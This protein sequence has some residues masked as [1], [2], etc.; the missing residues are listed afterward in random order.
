MNAVERISAA[1]AQAQN[2]LASALSQLNE[3]RAAY[4]QQAGPQYAKAKAD[5][6]ALDAKIEAAL[7]EQ[8]E[9]AADFQREFAAAGFEKTPAVAA[10]LRRRGEAQAMAESMMA[11]RDKLESNMPEIHIKA[12][13]LARDYVVSYR[14][15]QNVYAQT[16]AYEALLSAGATIGRAM[17]LLSHVPNEPTG[18]EDFLGRPPH[19][20]RAHEELS[21]ARM[22]SI[23]TDLCA[24]AYACPEFN[25]FP[26]FDGLGELDLI[27]L[28]AQDILSPAQ[29]HNLR[30]ASGLPSA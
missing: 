10:A 5:L 7:D 27:A 4:D 15:A 11:G 19:S 17:A 6:A 18:K 24:F 25:E 2:K 13:H 22:G 12:S 3:A 1:A 21:L 14:V 9:A 30:R 8:N 20:A 28:R 23:W 26:Q 29:M 16:Q